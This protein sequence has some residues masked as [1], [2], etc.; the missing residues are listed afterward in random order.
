MGCLQLHEQCSGWTADRS[1]KQT[2]SKEAS[3]ALSIKMEL[4]KTKT[5]N[6]LTKVFLL[7]YCLF[8]HCHKSTFD[9]LESVAVSAAIVSAAS[10]SGTSYITSWTFFFFLM[11]LL[12]RVPSNVIA[13]WG[14]PIRHE[15]K[16]KRKERKRKKKLLSRKYWKNNHR[17]L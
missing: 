13:P 2:S 6:K 17:S 7:I 1:L 11:L 10:M 15:K 5:K 16:R 14:T 8:Y 4:R 3:L 12:D 9:S